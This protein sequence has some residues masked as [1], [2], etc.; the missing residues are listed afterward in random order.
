MPLGR[1]WLLQGPDQTAGL[2]AALASA[3]PWQSP[4]PRL[5]YLSG[6]L[7]SGKTTLVAALLRAL[8][9]TEEVRSPSYALLEAYPIQP[10]PLGA[11]LAV[12][13][14]CYRL[15]D[16]EEL[17]VLGVRDYFN[18]RTLLLIEWPEQVRGALPAPDL[19]V[20]LEF[21]GV[22][23]RCQIGAQTMTG[24]QWLAAIQ[25]ESI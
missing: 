20:Q 6:E 13:M 5:A 19:A 11:G 9:V 10:G 23:R 1:E 2:G 8:G 22:G 18:Q 4:G 24:E 16:A 12:H 14:D 17:E 3:C 25:Y 21:E 15:R 7:G